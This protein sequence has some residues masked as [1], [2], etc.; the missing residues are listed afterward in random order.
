M[1]LIVQPE[2]G[3]PPVSTAIKQAKK[4]I[5]VLIFRLDLPEVAAF[6]FLE[7]PGSR[8]IADGYQL[9]QELGAVDAERIEV[10]AHQFAWHF[11]YPG[12][13]GRFGRT[14]PLHINDVV[15]NPFGID[16]ADVLHISAKTGEG[17]GAVLS[18]IVER[19]PPPSGA[20]RVCANSR[21]G[22]GRARQ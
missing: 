15:D 10:Y 19:V 20:P 13:D 11:R 16:P 9:L 6:P 1:K 8:A 3:T 7:P 4:T 14:S 21:P 5:D 22:R 18:A 17:I 12:P 2:A